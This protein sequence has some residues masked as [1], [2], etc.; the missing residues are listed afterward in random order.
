MRR[1]SSW[2]KSTNRVLG[3][4]YVLSRGASASSCGPV[5]SVAAGDAGNGDA[6][7]AD[8][9]AV[10]RVE[11][12]R[13]GALSAA[14]AAAAPCARARDGR[15]GFG[16]TAALVSAGS[17]ARRVLLLRR[18]V[19]AAAAGAGGAGAAGGVGRGAAGRGR[20]AS[21][22]RSCRT[23]STRSSHPSATSWPNVT[24][25]SRVVYTALM[26]A[27]ATPVHSPATVSPPSPIS[28]PAGF[29]RPSQT[30]HTGR[31]SPARAAH[32][33]APALSSTA[34]YAASAPAH[35]PP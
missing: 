12:R 24:I 25:R 22:A 32:R 1:P 2:T 9:L 13:F 20:A 5:A 30:S 14:P 19:R 26:S 6:V 4:G 27:F 34:P 35:W 29:V 33:C 16:E 10:R 31:W 21:A 7:S 17:A 3:L 15:L 8:P 11:A 23:S 18:G 28:A